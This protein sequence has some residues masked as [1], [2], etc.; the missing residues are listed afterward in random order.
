MHHPLGLSHADE[1]GSDRIRGASD[2]SCEQ[3]YAAV[4]SRRLLCARALMERA[5]AWA[6]DT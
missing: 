6:C 4:V 5:V 2:A 3:A 1:E